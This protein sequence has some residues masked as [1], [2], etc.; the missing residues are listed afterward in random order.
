MDGAPFDPAA[1]HLIAS[2]GHV[3][4]QVVAVIEEFRG[5]CSKADE[6]T[7]RS[8]TKIFQTTKDAKVTKWG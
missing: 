3:H 5:T 7:S 6:L 8:D 4:G 2:N 1:A